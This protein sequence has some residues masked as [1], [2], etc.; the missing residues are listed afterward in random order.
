MITFDANV[1]L[2]EVVVVGLGGT[3]AQVARSVARLVYEMKRSGLHAPSVRF[4][5]P[6]TVEEKNIGERR[7]EQGCVQGLRAR[8]DR[9][10]G[11]LWLLSLCG[12]TNQDQ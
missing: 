9:I 5:D 3:G 4:I 8:F 7:V 10:D 6:D 2:R 11:I 12:L 1:H